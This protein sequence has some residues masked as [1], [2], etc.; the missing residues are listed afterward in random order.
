MPGKTSA[1]RLKTNLFSYR[2]FSISNS[3]PG[4]TRPAKE[5]SLITAVS[6]FS[7]S[8]FPFRKW[9]KSSTSERR[10]SGASC[11]SFISSSFVLMAVYPFF[12]RSLISSLADPLQVYR[13]SNTLHS[14][15]LPRCSPA[16][17]RAGEAGGSA[18]CLRGFTSLSPNLLCLS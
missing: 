5:D 4:P 6:S 8:L 17:S 15:Y 14:L 9:T 1:L 7:R 2:W 18:P 11:I 16:E 13:R 12:Q 10:D 3:Y